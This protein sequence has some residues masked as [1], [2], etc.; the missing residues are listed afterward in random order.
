MDGIEVAAGARLGHQQDAGQGG[1]VAVDEHVVRVDHRLAVHVEGIGVHFGSHLEGGGILPHTVLSFL[2]H[3]HA[4]GV[5]G[6][7][8]AVEFHLHLLGREE[9]TGHLHPDRLGVLVTEGD[10]TVGIDDG[11][12]YA[13]SPEEGLLRESGDAER[14]GGRCDKDFLHIS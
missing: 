3:A 11:R 6:H 10:G 5:I 8:L 13:G 1:D 14:E 2:E 12:F 4:G 9:I 7:L